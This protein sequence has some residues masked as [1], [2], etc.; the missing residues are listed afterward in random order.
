MDERRKNRKKIHVNGK[1]GLDRYCQDME[2]R[3][4]GLSSEVRLPVQVEKI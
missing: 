3:K 2:S 4:T 1:E